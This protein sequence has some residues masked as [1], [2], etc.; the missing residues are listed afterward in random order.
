MTDVGVY[1]ALP[2]PNP[3]LNSL[4]SSSF[5]AAGPGLS[6]GL[7]LQGGGDDLRREVEVVAEVLDALVREVPVRDERN[8]LSTIF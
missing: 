1:S 3:H 2:R 6:S 8:C 5:A 4:A 7:S